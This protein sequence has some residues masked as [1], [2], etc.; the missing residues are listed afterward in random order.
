MKMRGRK[1]MTSNMRW[2]W[3]KIARSHRE[4]CINKLP[5]KFC[6]LGFCSVTWHLL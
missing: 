4:E 2:G 5:A 6:T 1:N 3:W